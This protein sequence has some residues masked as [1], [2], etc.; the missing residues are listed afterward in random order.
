MREDYQSA[1]HHH[2]GGGDEFFGEG[3]MRVMQH[4]H[5]ALAAS[6]HLVHA[7]ILEWC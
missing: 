6:H 3:A 7:G 5:G 4:V 2:L 1:T